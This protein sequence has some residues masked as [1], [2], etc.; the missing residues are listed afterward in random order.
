MGVSIYDIEIFNN[1][2]ITD[3]GDVWNWAIIGSKSPPVGLLG[4]LW[5]LW[6]LGLLGYQG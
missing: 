6:L 5:L 2:Y 3:D 4:L 1:T